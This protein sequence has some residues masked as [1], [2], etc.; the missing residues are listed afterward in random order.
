MV[1]AL[2]ISRTQLGSMLWHI[3]Q[4]ELSRQHRNKESTGQKVHA[5]FESTAPPI[6]HVASHDRYHD[7]HFIEQCLLDGRQVS[8]KYEGELD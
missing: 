5:A 8:P 2:S 1:E 6:R 7:S 3:S 4:D